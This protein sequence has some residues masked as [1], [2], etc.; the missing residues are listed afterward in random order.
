MIR[1][2]FT[3]GNPGGVKEA[4]VFRGICNNH[5]RLPLIPVSNGLKEKICSEMKALML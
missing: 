4:L 2:L 1:L 5:M 3:E